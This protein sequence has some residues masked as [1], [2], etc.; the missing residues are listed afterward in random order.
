MTLFYRVINYTL[1]HVMFQR[2]SDPQWR[3]YKAPGVSQLGIAG[4]AMTEATPCSLYLLVAIYSVFMKMIELSQV[5][6]GLEAD[7]GLF[8]ESSQRLTLGLKLC[9][10]E[11]RIIGMESII[12]NKDNRK[13]QLFNERHGL[14]EKKCFL[15]RNFATQSFFRSCYRVIVVANCA[16]RI[17]RVG[18]RTS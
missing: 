6:M 10:Y 17:R 9:L 7:G 3:Y 2:R 18:N 8:P 5:R 4:V 16:I 15:D 1:R 13:V 12:L 14:K 11:I